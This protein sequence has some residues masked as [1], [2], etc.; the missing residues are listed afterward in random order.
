MCPISWSVVLF[1]ANRHVG[2][3]AVLSF[4]ARRGARKWRAVAP[5][6]VETVVRP[7]GTE[8]WLRGEWPGGIN[9]PGSRRTGHEPRS[10]P[11][12]HCPAVGQHAQVPVSKQL[13]ITSCDFHQPPS[14]PPVVAM[15]PLVFPPGPSNEILV[16]APEKWT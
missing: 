3:T 2:S 5:F 11:G 16:D 12:S 6:P 9:P 1:Q 15:Q 10:S 13:R 8:T 7:R 4:L 14:R